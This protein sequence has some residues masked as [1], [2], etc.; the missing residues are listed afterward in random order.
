MTPYTYVAG[1]LLK[2]MLWKTEVRPAKLQ[3]R[4]RV[5]LCFPQCN[6]KSPPPLSGK[7]KEKR[8]EISMREG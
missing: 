7:T 3:K 6:K 4:G 1:L 8:A 5:L 2:I